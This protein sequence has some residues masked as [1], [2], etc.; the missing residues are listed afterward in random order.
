MATEAGGERIQASGVEFG[1]E[2]LGNKSGNVDIDFAAD[3]VSFKITLTADVDIDFIGTLTAD[4]RYTVWLTV[5]QDGTGSHTITWNN[6][7]NTQEPILAAGANKQTTY[8]IST[9]DQGSTFDIEAVHDGNS[10]TVGYGLSDSG[11]TF[12]AN[13]LYAGFG[14]S[15]PPQAGA[16]ANQSYLGISGRFNRVAFVGFYIGTGSIIV[17]GKDIPGTI[18]GGSATFTTVAFVANV[19]EVNIDHAITPGT[20]TSNRFNVEFDAATGPGNNTSTAVFS[21]LFSVQEDPKQ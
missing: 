6:T 10:R 19:T 8:I 1:H 9:T 17:S 3:N 5:V 12:N 13:T 20:S 4:R 15:S 16:L 2:D 7:L 14:Y 21:M 18:I 11:G